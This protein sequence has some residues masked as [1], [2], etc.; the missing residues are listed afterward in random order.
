MVRSTNHEAPHYAVFCFVGR[1]NIVSIATG[2][3][4]GIESQWGRDFPQL[5]RPA[6]EPTQPPV[7][8]VPSLSQG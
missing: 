2:Y 1:G 4:L 3:G 8:W 5:S 6:L 7:K